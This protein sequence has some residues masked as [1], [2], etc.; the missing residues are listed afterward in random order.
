[1]Y[2]L[3]PHGELEKSIKNFTY[4][5]R[6]MLSVIENYARR[7][8]KAVYLPPTVPLA[9]DPYSSSNIVP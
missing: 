2:G 1:M 5:T 8:C 9:L 7:E 4:L 3:D 6:K